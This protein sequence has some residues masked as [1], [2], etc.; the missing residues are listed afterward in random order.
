MSC[1]WE[2]LP[3][4]PGSLLPLWGQPWV[5]V[6][7]RGAKGGT[8][9]PNLLWVLFSHGPT[10]LG[11]GGCSHTATMAM[12]LG[13]GEKKTPTP[14]FPLQAPTSLYLFIYLG[15]GPTAQAGNGPISGGSAELG[16]KEPHCASCP[17]APHPG[18]AAGAR[19]GGSAWGPGRKEAW[20]RGAASAPSQLSMKGLLCG[21]G[22]GG[23]R[24]PT[25]PGS[26]EARMQGRGRP[27][28]TA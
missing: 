24:V 26:D 25:P 19:G 16:N 11:G 21:G 5:R 18:P 28:T 4:V 9:G 23:C 17:T 14:R 6:G 15:K 2:P 20:G 22:T 12:G 7:T 13:W 1:A 27:L 8:G 10:K 3:G